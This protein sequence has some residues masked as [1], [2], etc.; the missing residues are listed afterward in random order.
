MFLLQLA[1][2]ESDHQTHSRLAEQYNTIGKFEI[3]FVRLVLHASRHSFNWI[4][5]PVSAENLPRFQ[6][7]IRHISNVCRVRFSYNKGTA[8]FSARKAID[9]KVSDKINF[10][11]CESWQSDEE[12]LCVFIRSLDRFDEVKALLLHDECWLSSRMCHV[13]IWTSLIYTCKWAKVL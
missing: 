13:H 6:T 2:F 1:L 3:I 9:E 11:R 10:V 8:N 4:L 5:I 12:I 7:P